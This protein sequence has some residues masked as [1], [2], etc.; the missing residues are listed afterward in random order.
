MIVFA[1]F[2]SITM[3][4]QSTVN[5]AFSTST[6]GS[7][8]V[9]ANGNAIDM[10]TG[11]TALVASAVDQGASAVTN[12]G[13]NFVL[14]GNTYT[15]FSASSN[16]TMALG[17]T[18]IGTAVYSASGGTVV[19][20]LIAPWGSDGVTAGNG[21]ISKV[22]GTA[23][24]RCLVVE[25]NMSLYWLGSAPA[26]QMQVRL[27]ETTSVIQIVYGSMAM[28]SSTNNGAIG[29]AVGSAANTLAS[30]TNATNTVSTTTWAAN[31]TTASSPITNLDSSAN[32]SRRVYTFTPPIPASAT[33]LNF[34][35][36]TGTTT[37]LNWT[38]NATNE[39]G[40]LIYR[41]TDG[42]N[43]I[44][45]NTTAAN[46]VTYAATGLN[47]GTT[48]YW[49]VVP[50]AEG[51]FGSNLDG[52]Q[53]TLAGTLSGTKTV[54]TGG[55]YSNLTTAFAAI[56]ANGLSGNINLELI[57]GYPAIPETFPIV[58]PVGTSYNVKVY[59]TT[60]STPLT[61]S[62]SSAAAVFSLN[63]TS[64]LTIDGRV[65]Q[66]GSS[67]M[68]IANLIPAGATAL[69]PAT[70]SSITGTT[71]TVGSLAAGSGPLLIGQVLSGT[72]VTPGT[73]I[74]GYG[75]G[76]TGGAGT[77]TVS[78]S[79]TVTATTFTATSPAG[80][81][82]AFHFLNDASNNTLQYLTITSANTNANSGSIVFGSG[83]TSG[84]DNNNINNCTITANA[85]TAVVTGS[86]ALTAITVSGVTSGF[87]VPGSTVSGTG[88]T[89]GTIITAAGTGAGG[90]GTYTVNTSATV[91]SGILTVSNFP[92]NAIY[93]S[94]TSAAVD[95]S[96]NT[97]NNNQISDYYR[98]R[99]SIASSTRHPRAS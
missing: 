8:A 62:T 2:A 22:V 17:A 40:Y 24:N 30:I 92:V 59:P 99:L 34:T 1:F 43:Y 73:V 15:Q 65:N 18:A 54:G 5:Y 39:S 58:G 95:N 98:T 86:Q 45:V 75:S 13:F 36:V 61:I 27:Y 32:G 7:L 19:T 31:T 64:N 48:Y 56:T 11:T 46:I 12:I 44:L 25:F 88:V 16:G 97:L 76:T 23:P 28:G 66:T 84:N 89:A 29:F 35:A 72:G 68:S 50:F 21:V 47:Y 63:N 57:T 94:G 10:S 82:T 53:A 14:M 93:S 9:D 42:V 83:L 3:H 41:S 4:G 90:A 60:V 85:S 38:D 52:S 81:A 67:V 71:F 37:T 26:S 6:T 51:G 74:T 79:Q 80:G 69:T 77:Y 70:G 20:P 91:A 55:D 49:R 96:G 78:P 87:I 33:A